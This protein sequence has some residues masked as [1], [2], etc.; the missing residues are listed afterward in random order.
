[1]SAKQEW[2]VSAR[3]DV[4]YFLLE[5]KHAL[6][7]H[8]VTQKQS[9]L[10]KRQ[11][12][13]LRTLADCGFSLWRAVFLIEDSFDKDT[14]VSDMSKFMDLLI[15]DNAINYPQDKATRHFSASYYLTSAVQ[16]LESFHG[17]YIVDEPETE[18]TMSLKGFD[19]KFH[20]VKELAAK[21]LS[22]Q[23]YSNYIEIFEAT[24]EAA[25]AL[26]AVL[27]PA[28]GTVSSKSEARRA[29]YRTHLR[30]SD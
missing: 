24:L 11:I 29:I 9:D 18:F 5:I 28:A 6:H 15:E 4:Q 14:L 25:V 10:S 16:R 7:Q 3:S 20:R 23:S 2:L 1:M 26:S 8:S 13:F 27:C 19:A 21:S 22:E 12:H 30:G 17:Y